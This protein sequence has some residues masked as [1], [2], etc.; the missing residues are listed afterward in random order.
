[1]VWGVPGHLKTL[2]T[3]GDVTHSGGEGG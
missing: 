3:T 1:L 2:K